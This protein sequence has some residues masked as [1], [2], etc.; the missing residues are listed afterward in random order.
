MDTR[1]AGVAVGAGVTV[2]LTVAV[3]VIELVDVEF[4]ALVGLPVGLL[5]GVAVTV[6][7]A[8]RYGALVGFV[9]Y[10]VDAAAG[11]GF[12]IVALLAVSYVNLGGLRT[13]LSTAVTVGIALLTAAVAAV[14]S[15]R[16]DS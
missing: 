2:F 15:W 16:T 7:I 3:A 14:A 12:A 6:G 10:T 13:E 9:R 8:M 5:A 1:A 11:F 4:S